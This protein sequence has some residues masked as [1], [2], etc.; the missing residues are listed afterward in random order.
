M[1]STTRIRRLNSE[2]RD[3]TP[4]LAVEFSQMPASV[5]ERDLSPIRC[6]FLRDTILHGSVVLP[7][8]WARA[9]VLTDGGIY[10]VNG[11]HSSHVLAEMNGTMPEGLVAVIDDWE[12][13]TIADLPELFRQFDSR[14]SAR[15]LGDISGAYQMVEPDLRAIPRRTGKKAIE[16]VAWYQKHI[17]G[18]FVPADDLI[19]S[20]F[21]EPQ[22]HPF[23]LFA[24]T[25]LSLKTPEFTTPVVAAMFGTHERSPGRADEFWQ[26]VATEG[27]AFDEKHPA[28]V[29][30]AWLVAAKEREG[31]KPGAMEVFRACALAWNA[32]RNGRNLERIG[33]FD[34]KK[35]APELE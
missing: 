13:A 32:Y 31:K 1:P 14:R 21:Q 15:S 3:V 20:L 26:A 33:R 28:T 18:G 23:V 27:A 19:Y 29:L 6:Q 7:F 2:L 4:E 5:T 12:V 10:R 22:F 34:P 25:I 24:G 16:G 9:K 11:H 35:G 8:Q 30:D 17:F